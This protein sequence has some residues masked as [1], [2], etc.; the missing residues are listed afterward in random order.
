MR[1][2]SYTAI[3]N[4]SFWILLFIFIFLTPV[5]VYYSLGYKFDRG[6]N[7]FL[8]TGAISI[9]TYPKGVSIY[10]SGQKLN[11]LSPCILR[12]Y[13][14]KEY[15][16]SLEKEG[17]YSY[18]IPVEVNPAMVSEI[19]VVLIPKMKNVEKLKFD[20]N[21]YKFFITKHF[22]GEKIILFTDKGIYFADS[23]F[24]N[25][26]KVST[27]ALGEDLTDTIEGL[28]ESNNRLLFWSKLN[29]W[30]LDISK[31]TDNPNS[32][33]VSAYKAEENIK[34]VFFGIRDR[35]LL[36]H[37]GL[38]VIALD[39]QNPR[40]Y[41]TVLE[42]KSMNSRIFYDTASE[43][44]YIRDK[45][46]QTSTFSLFKIELIPLINERKETEKNF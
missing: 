37:D 20:F 29:V 17:F 26:R 23:D 6:S 44:L 14:P 35:Y 30:L 41:F 40:A 13:L 45:I 15:I 18:Q 11:E 7:K 24:Q 3:R 12:D 10:I 2:E 25:V 32:D 1:D 9:K 33:L 4:F 27:K 8:K 36:V 31:S 43:T 5:T 46:P 39:A 21:V 28:R 19:N 38:K 42:L 22:F 34:D 16:I